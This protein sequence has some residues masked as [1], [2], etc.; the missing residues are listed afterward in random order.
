[1]LS[2][3]DAESWEEVRTDLAAGQNPGVRLVPSHVMAVALVQQRG[4]TYV[5]P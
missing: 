1:M 4:F 5:K 2:R 3:C